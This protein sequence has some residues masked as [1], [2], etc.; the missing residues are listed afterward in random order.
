[1]VNK[2]QFYKTKVA[3]AVVLS[4][5][6]AAC[7]DSDGD[8]GSTSVSESVVEGNGGN[9][10]EQAQGTGSV[11]GTVLD[12]NG[13]PVMGATV[14]LAG[15]SVVTDASGYYYFTD[16]PVSGVSGANDSATAT[17]YTVTITAPEGYAGAT[18]SVT[19]ANIQLDSGNNGT[20]AKITKLKLL[21]SKL[22]GLTV[23]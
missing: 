19:T 3:L 14:S 8:A 6:L 1:M 12:T 7:G 16:V 15:Q 20:N 23:S 22:H 17:P 9:T 10:V 5:G 21:A 11:Q 2:T 4:L 18:V 13:L